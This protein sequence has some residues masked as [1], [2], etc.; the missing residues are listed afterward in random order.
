MRKHNKQQQ[1]EWWQERRNNGDI[2][3]AQSFLERTINVSAVSS[4]LAS[5]LQCN[6][7]VSDL[8]GACAERLPVCVSAA[9][10]QHL[11][12]PLLLV[13]CASIFKF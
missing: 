2:P 7:P 12:L 1:Q 6:P 13:V 3:T 11:Q 10:L 9:L 8:L 5:G 4:S